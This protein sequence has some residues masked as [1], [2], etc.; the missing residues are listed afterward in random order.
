MTLSFILMVPWLRTLLTTFQRWF[1]GFLGVEL[2]QGVD[3]VTIRP[4]LSV[5]GF[6]LIHI[7]DVLRRKRSFYDGLHL[8][9]VSRS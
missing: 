9:E 6:D 8:F 1:T 7:F 4:V 3:T 2:D 5:T